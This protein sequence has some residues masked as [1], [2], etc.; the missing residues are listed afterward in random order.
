M[1]RAVLDLLAP[2]AVPRGWL[3]VSRCKYADASDAG[4]GPSRLI[5][6]GVFDDCSTFIGYAIIHRFMR[7]LAPL[8]DANDHRYD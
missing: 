1:A 7:W 8:A 6:Q 2:N 3:L 5:D 4:Y